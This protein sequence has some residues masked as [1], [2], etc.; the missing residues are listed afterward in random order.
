ML[1]VRPHQV[2]RLYL[3]CIAA[4]PTP[5]DEVQLGAIGRYG[6][7]GFSDHTG[8]V[9]MGAYAVMAGARILEAHLRADDTDPANPDSRVALNPEGFVQY[10][11]NVREAEMCFGVG[12]SWHSAS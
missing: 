11:Q 5:M 12:E 9:Q 8:L 2:N 6:L 4:Y 10:V 3:H 1:R 7:D